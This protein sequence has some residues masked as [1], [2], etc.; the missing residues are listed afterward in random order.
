MNSH[1]MLASQSGKGSRFSFR[2][3][4]QVN[5]DGSFDFI[6][7]TRATIYTQAHQLSAQG[8]LLYKYLELFQVQTKVIHDLVNATLHESDVLFLDRAY[9]Q[10][11]DRCTAI[12]LSNASNGSDN[13]AR[14]R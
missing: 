1:L 4:H 8:A 13:E 9:L 3:T 12:D 5:E 10:S 7:G 2:I 6:D 11:T 14:L